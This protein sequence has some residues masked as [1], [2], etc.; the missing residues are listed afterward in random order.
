M[1][2][3]AAIV[4]EHEEALHSYGVTHFL[5]KPYHPESPAGPHPPGGR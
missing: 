2:C 1:I 3:S 5:T 4:R